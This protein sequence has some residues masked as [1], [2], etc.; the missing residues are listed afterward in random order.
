MSRIVSKST[1]ADWNDKSKVNE[2]KHSKELRTQ[3]NPPK[4]F[5]APRSRGGVSRGRRAQVQSMRQHSSMLDPSR[6][7]SLLGRSASEPAEYREKLHDYRE[8]KES[9]KKSST[10]V[11]GKLI[12]DNVDQQASV[13]D[14]IANSKDIATIIAN[15]IGDLDLFQ[16]EW[17]ILCLTIGGK[18]LETYCDC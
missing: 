4:M 18:Y 2:M 7:A 9:I 12:G 14:K 3:V 10:Q 13:R 15:R 8:Y 6:L 5:Q 1:I 16:N 11:L 17:L